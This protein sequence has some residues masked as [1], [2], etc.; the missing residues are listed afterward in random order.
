MYQTSAVQLTGH[1]GYGIYLGHLA[2]LLEELNL[3]IKLSRVKLGS[4]CTT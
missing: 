1:E 3:L 4:S 2:R